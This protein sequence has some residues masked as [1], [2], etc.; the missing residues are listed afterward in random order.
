MKLFWDNAESKTSA[1]PEHKYMMI[2]IV[3][4]LMM[5]IAM[6]M[7]LNMLLLMILRMANPHV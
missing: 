1:I 7:I 5:M 6:M 4:M 3:M 2:E